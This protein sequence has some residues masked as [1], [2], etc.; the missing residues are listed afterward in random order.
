VRER[1]ERE[2][3]RREKD[4]ERERERVLKAENSKKSTSF[5]IFGPLRSDE[6][7]LLLS[8]DFESWSQS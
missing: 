4:R 7:L 2:R 6:F 8:Y 5:T 3:E 1:E